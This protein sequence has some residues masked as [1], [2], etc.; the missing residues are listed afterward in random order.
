MPFW[1]LFTYVT[2]GNA[3]TNRK[4]ENIHYHDGLPLTLLII[5]PPDI[6]DA[7]LASVASR[8]LAASEKP[9]IVEASSRSLRYS[10]EFLLMGGV[11]PGGSLNGEPSKGLT[12]GESANGFGF[13]R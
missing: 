5:R 13:D 6:T 7:F 9:P 2:P 1:S 4:Q 11:V 10:D 12:G 8:I 3:S